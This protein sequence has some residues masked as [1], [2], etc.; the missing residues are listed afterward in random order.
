MLTYSSTYFA[1]ASVANPSCEAIFCCL[2]ADE[3]S[4]P[5]S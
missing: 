1:V 5:H 2:L 4:E 3:V